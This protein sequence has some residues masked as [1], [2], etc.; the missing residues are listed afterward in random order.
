MIG[1]IWFCSALNLI[2]LSNV[3]ISFQPLQRIGNH[4][5]L[6]FLH[7][8]KKYQNYKKEKIGNRQTW[9]VSSYG[10]IKRMKMD[11]VG[12]AC[13]IW[14]SFL[15][16][17]SLVYR[18]LRRKHDTMSLVN[19]CCLFLCKFSFSNFNINKFILIK[20]LNYKRSPP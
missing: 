7:L 16:P 9:I 11:L 15:F 13:E 4:Y 18:L 5:I 8:Y 10:K 2:F 14:D 12:F 6:C 17:L 3:S 20:Q 19:K 1:S